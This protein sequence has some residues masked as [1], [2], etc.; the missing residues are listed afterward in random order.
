[1]C[2]DVTPLHWASMEGRLPA[3]KALLSHG[4]DVNAVTTSYGSTPLMEAAHYGHAEVCALLLRHGAAVDHQNEYG[5][6]ALMEASRYGCVDVVK[7]LLGV[8]RAAVDVVSS[9][10]RTA[11]YW[12][13]RGKHDAIVH[14]LLD[15]G[16]SLELV[17][18]AKPHPS[19]PEWVLTLIAQR[20]CCRHAA[21]VVLGLFRKRRPPAMR[22]NNLDAIR[23]VAKSVW[24]TRQDENWRPRK[25]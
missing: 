19:I 9:T 18:A 5:G 22:G 7:L 11:L 21:V 13:I 17:R 25:K 12:A 10:G 16:A 2:S 15:A 24:E 23:L 3:V 6:T 14:A 8:G 20:E 1:M 4:S